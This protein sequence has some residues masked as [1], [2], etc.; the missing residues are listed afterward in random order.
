MR[1]NRYQEAIFEAVTQGSGHLV[2][3]ALAGTGKTTTIEEAVRR[4]LAAKPGAR[5]LATAFNRSVADVLQKRLPEKA[6]A[7]TFHS[8]G[9][10]ALK[11]AWG[12]R[13]T[14]VDDQDLDAVIANTPNSLPYED[15]QI[16]KSL[17][18]IA[19]SCLAETRDQILDLMEEHNLKPE[20]QPDAEV[21]ENRVNLYVNTTLQILKETIVP[22]DDISYDDMVYIP[23]K[24]DMSTGPFDVVFVDETQDMN[25]VQIQLARNAVNKNGGRLVL[26]GDSH[27]AI[28]SW[29]GAD[30]EVMSRLATELKAQKLPLPVSYR[31]SRMVAAE[32]RQYVPE[33][34]VPDDA[35]EGR[36]RHVPVTTMEDAWREGDYVL[37]RTNAPLFQLCLRAIQLGHCARIQGSDLAV[38][39][40]VMI[41]RSHA[42]SIA[43]FLA[44][45]VPWQKSEIAK[46]VAAKKEHKVEGIRDRARA[47]YELSEGLD[48]IPALLDRMRLL[49]STARGV[50]I[51]FSTVHKAKGLEADRV[52]MIS[53]TFRPERSQEEK[54]L[55]YV[56]VTRAKSELFLV[57]L[58]SQARWSQTDEWN[59]DAA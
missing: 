17:V 39:L 43:E 25:R 38:G 35:R 44:W 34:E 58:P 6:E 46:A 50:P 33:F 16:I 53:N 19:K 54:N 23:A 42:K 15:R 3:E 2:V 18:S 11:R 5:V 22:H 20:I 57:S 49:T 36:V 59:D 1:W 29:R 40:E 51:L 41:K 30:R 12:S 31:C 14:K 9:L 28:Y 55:W 45:L 4:L 7:R 47:I 21:Y 37:S 52:W 24:L 32:A 26:V 10:K 13:V 8:L 48:R 56:A 27:Q